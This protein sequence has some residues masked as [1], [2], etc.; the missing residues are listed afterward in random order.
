MAQRATYSQVAN[1]TTITLTIPG[2]TYSVGDS[3]QFDFVTGGAPSGLF[4]VV[5]SS[6][7]TLTVTGADVPTA[8]RNGNA[9]V[10]L[11]AHI[12]TRSG[13][14]VAT[15]ESY[16]VNRTGGNV[17][18]TFS[19]WGINDTD[20]DLSQT[21]MRSPTVFNFFEPDYRSPGLL[22][23]AGLITPEFQLTSDTTV[24]RQANFIYSGMFN[25]LHGIQGLSS[26]NNGGRDIALDFRPWM[27]VGPGG[28]PW[29][30]NNNLGAF[31]NQMSALLMAGQ[32]PSTGVNDYT[33][34]PRTIVN[35]KAVITD[36]AQSLPYGRPMSSAVNAAALTT[37][38][39]TAHGYTTGDS[40]T[41]A[42][43]S[44]GGFSNG[45]RLLTVT[46]PNTFTVPTTCTTVTA[47]LTAATATVGGVPKPITALSGFSSVSVSNHGFATGQSITISGVTGGTFTP[48]INGTHTAINDGNT[49]SFL[50]PVTRTNNTGQIVTDARVFIPGGFPDL[51][52]DRIRAIVHL[53]VT[54][55]D[56]IIQK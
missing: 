31:V 21:P 44:G 33:S 12:V 47:N 15:R 25:D 11:P 27:G 54:S 55:P 1:S 38:T 18:L 14:L 2:H 45:T 30:H 20:N 28:L 16:A 22:A 7:P 24:M 42:G 13:A 36:Y 49:N 29:V 50:I 8:V 3:L 9:N 53:M 26:F 10:I 35:A 56:F 34:N 19:D 32:L 52:R 23:Q 6:P 17:A 5:N 51:I 4:S 46:G 39:V 40:V 37:V 41:I 48:A 43:V